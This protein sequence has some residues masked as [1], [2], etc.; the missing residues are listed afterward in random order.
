MFS[1]VFVCIRTVNK[2]RQIYGFYAA[3]KEA[4]R[5]GSGPSK[6]QISFESCREALVDFQVLP[7]V[8][9][10]Q[11]FA[12]LFKISKLWEL[13]VAEQLLSAQEGGGISGGGSSCGGGTSTSGGGVFFTEVDGSDE[14]NTSMGSAASL[15][16]SQQGHGQGQGLSIRTDGH[17]LPKQQASSFSSATL[18]PGP[19]TP[20]AAADSMSVVRPSDDPHDFKG[21][22]GNLCLSIW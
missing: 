20:S 11:G 2:I 6:L 8:V 18:S 9:D 3:S 13:Q 4:R 5:Q 10:A 19:G 14:L 15:V 16:P 7:H 17:G 12:R 21:S 22:V 1:H